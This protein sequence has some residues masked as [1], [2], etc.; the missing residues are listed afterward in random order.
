MLESWLYDMHMGVS[1]CQ[2][3]T[4]SQVLLTFPSS[5]KYMSI[6]YV[7]ECL[8][9]QFAQSFMNFGQTIVATHPLEITVAKINYGC[10][11]LSPFS[12]L[13]L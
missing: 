3:E 12:D 2:I 10:D 11:Q 13:L 9:D 5:C 8:A 1:G 6:L 7:A 4:M